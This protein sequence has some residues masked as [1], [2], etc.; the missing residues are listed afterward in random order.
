MHTQVPVSSDVCKDTHH[1]HEQAKLW[2]Q[3]HFSLGDECKKIK[4][5]LKALSGNGLIISIMALKT[6]LRDQHMPEL[7]SH[8]SF[9]HQD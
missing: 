2:R 8:M 5:K 3:I 1:T 7:G 4:K 6:G 9:R